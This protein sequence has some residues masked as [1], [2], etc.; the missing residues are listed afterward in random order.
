MLLWQTL[1][2]HLLVLL[3][4][5]YDVIIIDDFRSS[6]HQQSIVIGIVGQSLF[7]GRRIE[8]IL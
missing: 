8:I 3:Y 1:P 4:I 6:L 7:D 5:Y 2:F